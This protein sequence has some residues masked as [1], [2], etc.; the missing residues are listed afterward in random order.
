MTRNI[1]VKIGT[2]FAFFILTSSFIWSLNYFNHYQL[3]QKLQFM[4]AK[5]ELLNSILEAR[6]YEKNFF[7]FRNS[8]DLEQAVTYVEGAER[9]QEEILSTYS[10][11]NDNEKLELRLSDLKQYKRGLVSLLSLHKRS[12]ELGANAISNS[13]ENVRK[14]GQGITHEIEKT[15]ERQK[16][17]IKEL[18]EETSIYLHMA[19]LALVIL[20]TGTIL[21]VY[22]RINGPLKRI[23][24]AIY[25]IGKGDYTRIPSI[26]T[27]DIF[28]SLV[29]SLNRMLA[30]LNRRKDQ[31][32]H[33]NKMASLGTLTSGVAHELNN[34]LNNISTCIQILIEEID[35]SD[36]DYKLELLRDADAQ[37]DRARDII[38]DL[39]D[40][41]RD[42][43]YKPVRVNF[44]A[45]VGK[46]FKLIKGE[47]PSHLAF[48]VCIPDDLVVRVSPYRIQRV[49]M[50]LMLNAIHA[51]ETGG[52][53]SV[54]AM[55]TEKGEWC[56]Q[57]KDTGKGIPPENI[58]KIFDPFFTTKDV[59]HGTGL[60]LAVSHGIIEQHGGRIAVGSETGK[61]STFT[62]FLP[63]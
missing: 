44:R 16:E 36:R 15:V 37:T 18:I 9:K 33:A 1:R 20:T 62:V 59:G 4:D 57:V 10:R 12:P 26:D 31:L 34:P 38:K 41:S 3:T 19:L 32:L 55:A 8:G 54:E 48:H 43:K 60:G 14:I 40:F 49:L 53:L 47:F 39:L 61:G 50:N 6:R 51:M 42:R 63:S 52:N 25:K 56:F 17:I 23:E 30:E 11:Y 28:V 5:T 46:T 22:Y 35:E 27:G 13:Q 24:S 29:N 21:L 45:L 58:P 7:L 2:S